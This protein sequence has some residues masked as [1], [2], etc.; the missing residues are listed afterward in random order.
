M[1]NMPFLRESCDVTDVGI[2]VRETVG[3]NIEGAK[4]DGV[5]RMDASDGGRV[6]E[7]LR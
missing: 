2:D 6:S 5:L 7:A 4:E 1:L 3:F